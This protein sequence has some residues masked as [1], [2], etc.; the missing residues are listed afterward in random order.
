MFYPCFPHWFQ[1]DVDQLETDDLKSVP[2]TQNMATFES[3]CATLV[4]L[5][6]FVGSAVGPPPH[7]PGVFVFEVVGI[8][9]R[10]DSFFSYFPNPP[11]AQN[12]WQLILKLPT[13][14]LIDAAVL[15]LETFQFSYVAH[16]QIQV[17]VCC[18]FYI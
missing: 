6:P 12:I 2:V 10:K 18:I 15:K 5:F 3:K 16:H 13:D 8:D 17:K 7:S 9:V 1:V 11:I 14:R 4:G